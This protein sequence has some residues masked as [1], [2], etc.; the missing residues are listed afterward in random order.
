MTYEDDWGYGK[1][2]DE[3]IA[4]LVTLIRGLNDQDRLKVFGN[5][6]THC[7]IEDPGCRCWNNE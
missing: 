5:F 4:A 6:C 3:A 2:A 1:P 7:G